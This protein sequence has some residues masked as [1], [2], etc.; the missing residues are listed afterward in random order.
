MATKFS[1]RLSRKVRYLWHPTTGQHQQYQYHH[2]QQQP[3]SPSGHSNS[4]RPQP[5]ASST[6]SPSCT[7]QW[8]H[9]TRAALKA[10]TEQQLPKVSTAAL[11]LVVQL[12][13]DAADG[14]YS[15]GKVSAVAHGACRHAY[16][17]AVAVC[18]RDG[19]PL[20]KYSP[21]GRQQQQHGSGGGGS[22]AATA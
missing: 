8:Q 15:K 20:S 4:Q 19:E 22:R 9:R 13:A 21:D 3:I 7:P 1:E 12:L 2:Q 11:L 5:R 6:G 14:T 18:S 17:T 16:C 10:A